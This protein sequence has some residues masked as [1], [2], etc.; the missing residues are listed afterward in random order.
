MPY[1]VS[2]PMD[3]LLETTLVQM[4]RSSCKT[5]EVNYKILGSKGAAMAYRGEQDDFVHAEVDDDKLLEESNEETSE[6]SGDSSDEKEEGQISDEEEDEDEVI[7]DPVIQKCIWEGD[8]VK[9]RTILKQRKEECD[10]LKKE[11][12]KEKERERELQKSKEMRELLEELQ[13]V[14]KTK[15]SLQKSLENSRNG[16]PVHS[17]KW[18]KNKKQDKRI[19]K[20]KKRK[21]EEESSKSEYNDTLQSLLKLKQGNSQEYSDLVMQAMSATDNIMNLKQSR[22]ENQEIQN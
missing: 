17:P 16:T 13:A 21:T 6:N 11:V 10:K 3:T 4:R 1:L 9:L 5:K 18:N 7:S 15:S 20:Q 19:V 22:E 14:S 12:A 2:F 8:L